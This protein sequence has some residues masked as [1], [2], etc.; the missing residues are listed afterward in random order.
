M[1]WEVGTTMDECVLFFSLL[2]GSSTFVPLFIDD[3]MMSSS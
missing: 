3:L 1:M 2:D